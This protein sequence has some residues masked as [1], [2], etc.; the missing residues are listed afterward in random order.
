[1]LGSGWSVSQPGSSGPLR[2]AEGVGGQAGE[3]GGASFFL[4]RSATWASNVVALGG[5]WERNVCMMHCME[6]QLGSFSLG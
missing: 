2:W 4:T 5:R 1:M 6:L 3:R